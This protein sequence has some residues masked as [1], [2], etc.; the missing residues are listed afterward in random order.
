MYEQV[1]PS[2][3]MAAYAAS[4]VEKLL[5]DLAFGLAKTLERSDESSVHDLRRVCLRLRHALRM[6]ARLLPG[7]GRRRIQRRLGMVQDLL[8]SVRSCD[9][10]LQVLSDQ[11]VAAA[12]HPREIK[13]AAGAVAAERRRALRPLRGRL[14]KM[15]R[16]DSVAR[17]RTRL[18]AA[19]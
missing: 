7:K 9:V 11:A 15:R 6:F 18:L 3:D 8:G 12:V 10:A 13:K 16:S 14:R 5:R 4:I 2:Q 1:K 19:V 17:W